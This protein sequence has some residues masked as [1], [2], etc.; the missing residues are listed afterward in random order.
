M[1]FFRRSLILGAGNNANIFLTDE[2]V[3]G[4]SLA[5]NRHFTH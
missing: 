3:G 4:N 5:Q 2:T 1:S